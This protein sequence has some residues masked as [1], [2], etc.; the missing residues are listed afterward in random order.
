VKTV[1]KENKKIGISGMYPN[2]ITNYVSD[3]VFGCWTTS[4]LWKRL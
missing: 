2:W 3:A 1:E 4:S